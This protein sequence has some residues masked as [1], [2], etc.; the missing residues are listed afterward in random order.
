MKVPGFAVVT[1]L[2]LSCC[3][4]EKPVQQ[5]EQVD[6]GA[7]RF[8][9]TFKAEGKEFGTYLSTRYGAN[10]V[11]LA[12][13]TYGKNYTDVFTGCAL[14]DEAIPEDY[15]AAYADGKVVISYKCAK[16]MGVD[17][18][19]ARLRAA[20]AELERDSD[21]D[22]LPDLAEYRFW[23]DATNPDTDGDGRSDGEDSNPLACAKAKLT[24]EQ[25]I[26]KAGFEQFRLD[27][28]YVRG[29]E[30]FLAEFEKE[31]DFFELPGMKEPVL[32]VTQDHVVKFAQQF[33]YVTPRVIFKR[34]IYGPSSE[35]RRVATF[36]I[37]EFYRPLQGLGYKLTL[38]QRDGE[39]KLVDSSVERIY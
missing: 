33:G 38:Q 27:L 5:R 20:L 28:R 16:L 31:L 24:D 37:D 21:S 35:G 8:D 4:A 26:W 39:W 19:H 22:G 36:E 11:W 7:R 18:E 2:M 34:V 12:Y 9:Y 10:D 3:S 13:S 29:N 14:L 30:I 32:A 25:K 15:T 17:A 6:V 1:L 23:T